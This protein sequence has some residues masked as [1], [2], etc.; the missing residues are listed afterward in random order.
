L[1]ERWSPRA[2]VRAAPQ[3]AMLRTA[4]VTPMTVRCAAMAS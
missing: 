2:A 1:G 3:S 4:H